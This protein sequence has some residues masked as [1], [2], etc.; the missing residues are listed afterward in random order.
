MSPGFKAA[1]DVGGTFTDFA[2]FDEES[3]RLLSYK[4]PSTP[5][6]PSLAVIEGFRQISAQLGVPLTDISVFI[7]GNTLGVNTVIQRTGARVSVLTTDGFR[8][9]L[10]LARLRLP[11]PFLMVQPRPEALVPRARV[12]EIVERISATGKEL[13]PLDTRHAEQVLQEVRQEGAE[14]IAIS[15][16]NAFANPE[17][18]RQ[19]ADLVR[20]VLP[21]AELSVSSEL[22]PEVREYERTIV[23]VI[24]AYI[25]PINSRYIQALLAGL[26]A[27]D[28]PAELYITRSNGGMMTAETARRQPVHTLLSGPAS[29]V[30]GAAYVARLAGEPRCVTLDM[31]GTS[32]DV[33]L[34]RD[35]EAVYSTENH[36]GDFPVVM[37]SVDVSAIGAGG[38]SIAWLDQL[39]I[40]HVGPRSAGAEP[41]PAC[42]GRGGNEPTVTDAYL[43]CGYIDPDNFI[44]GRIRLDPAL[45]EAA[46][47]PIA[48]R[49]GRS[50]VETAESILAVAT[51]NMATELLPLMAKKGI[52]P[53]DFALIVYGGAGPTHAARLAEE[54]RIGRIIVPPSPG[55]LCALGALM[56]DVR[57]DY[58]RTVREDAARVDASELCDTFAALEQQALA[59]VQDQGSIIRETALTRSADMRYRG[60]PYDVEV[61]VPAETELAEVT[62]D[63]L[64][65]LFHAAHQQVYNFMDRDAAVRITNVR[66]R[67]SGQPQLPAPVAI[68][69]AVDDAAP[70]E[71]RQIYYQGAW[72]PARV[73]ER[74]ELRSGHTLEGPA[75][76]EQFDTTTLIPPGFVARV[77]QFGIVGMTLAASNGLVGEGATLTGAAR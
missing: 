33:S 65:D 35:G 40:L 47:A 6:D 66:V 48:E 22:W 55:T 41:G 54:T 39:G 44:G 52:D 46:I 69:T 70:R 23:T 17:H 60:E 75:I 13:T 43:L 45:A 27:I 1:A 42:Y 68:G 49:M 73:F 51:S 59:W 58:I 18:E 74:A 57:N 64:V 10:E 26:K 32:A 62:T 5:A 63:A 37:P 2:L 20:Q 24:N 9:V 7:H 15:L 29:G 77:D 11:D 38:G 14:A 4:L 21:N 72:H 19:L 76:I 36:V 61:V 30:V 53:R 16:I 67:V 71:R 56:T 28:V 31:G 50:V 12:K 34:V 3:G 25:H 8:D